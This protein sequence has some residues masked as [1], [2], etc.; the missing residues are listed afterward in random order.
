MITYELYGLGDIALDTPVRFRERLGERLD[1][2]KAIALPAD[3]L[4]R[5][6]GRKPAP[7]WPENH[8]DPAQP[9]ERSTPELQATLDRLRALEDS[10]SWRLT[11]PL[12]AV[13]R[14]LVRD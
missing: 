8:P 2:E 12:R 10:I 11:A 14:A 5:A 1:V 9:V 3:P 4:C 13:R 7:L 6:P